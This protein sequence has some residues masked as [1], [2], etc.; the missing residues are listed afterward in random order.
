MS[1]NH[2]RIKVA[3]LETNQHN[4]ILITNLNGEL[5]FSDVSNLQTENYNE[6]DC[7]TEGKA[8]DARQGKVLKEMIDNKTVNLASDSETQS[9]TAVSEDNKV[10]SRSK[11]F[12]WW[13]WIKSQTHTISGAWNFTNKVTLA[14]GT[15]DIPSLIIPNG[16]LTSLYQ[17]GAIERDATGKLWTTRY[18]N[19]YMLTEDDGSYIKILINGKQR[20]LDTPA[21]YIS[22]NVTKETLLGVFEA[23]TLSNSILARLTMIADIGDSI[24]SGSIAPIAD[25]FQIVIK[26]KNAL[27]KSSWWGK[28][29]LNELVLIDN[30]NVTGTTA[31]LK[32]TGAHWDSEVGIFNNYYVF[33]SINP[34][35]SKNLSKVTAEIVCRR[36]FEFEDA[37]NSKGH[38]LAIRAWTNITSTFVERL[39]A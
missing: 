11:L 7:S 12:N 4:K 2:N 38:N 26:F 19:R 10:V 14:P 20:T 8:L 25:K 13:Q 17:N 23:G 29:Y 9:S 21:P 22:T 30:V 27:L 35:E 37:A 16:T 39:R 31:M 32:G 15:K 24:E 5:E 33:D 36:L 28:E 3:D 1:T 6:L 18:S 34:S